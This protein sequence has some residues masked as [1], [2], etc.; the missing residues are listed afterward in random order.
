MSNGKV[1]TAPCGH[2][3]RH[4]TANYVTCDLGC[5]SSDGVPV[6]VRDRE[7]QHLCS[8]CG[9]SNVEPWGPEFVISGKQMWQ[10]HSEHCGKS[11]VV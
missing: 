1:G 11:F 2:P 4:V 6:H 10:C 3:G 9:S 7:T 8:H 5:D